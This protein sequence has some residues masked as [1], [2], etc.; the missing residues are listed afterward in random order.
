MTLTAQAATL[1]NG[2]SKLN[3]RDRLAK[4]V[5]MR[6]L[7]PDDVTF[8]NMSTG[9]N[10][11]LAE[12][13]I[14]NVIGYFQLPLGVATHFC[15]DGRYRVIPMA[16][17]ETSIIAAASKTAKWINKRHGTI[18]TTL[19]GS[20][21]IGQIQ[22]QRV[23]DPDAFTQTILRNKAYLIHL[24]NQEIAA[25]LVRRG[26]GMR[27]IQVRQ[28]TRPDGDTMIV[29][30]VIVDTCDAMGANIVTQ[31][32][33]FLKTPIYD[34]TQQR[35]N[36]AIISNLPDCRLT[37]C[38]IRIPNLEPDFVAGITEAA[39]FAECDPYR[40]ATHNKGILNGIDPILI[41]T[42]NDWRAVEA[43]VHTYATRKQTCRTITRWIAEDDGTTL[44]GTLE[45]P[46][47]VAT[48]GGVTRLHPTAK[49][50][51]RL[52]DIQ[53]ADE[54]S[55]IIA[56]VGL[57]QNLG[58]LTA[59]S[60]VGLTQGHMR[61]HISNLTIEAGAKGAEIPLLK[62]RLEEILALRKRISLSHA[63]DALK[64]LRQRASLAKHA[65]E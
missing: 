14:E 24:A 61:L 49:L 22:C 56:A 57:V 48:V 54:L 13:F 35:A 40:A 30:H 1:F 31:L 46:L 8:L 47:P 55:R 12:N 39:L 11:D 52:L 45:A 25:G 2:F 36:I 34:L 19:H 3:R 27:D 16:V 15:I 53:H 9:L 18:T 5:E 64:E 63:V 29:C 41:A 59:L 6:A 65:N 26:G 51:L 7:T 58:A 44:I 38:H 20:G 42:G 50:S 60:T 37:Q 23:A 10:P 32:C 43:A 4:L 21:T 28:L 62:K 17:E 33:E